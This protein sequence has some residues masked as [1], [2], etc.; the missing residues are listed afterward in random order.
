[1]L[2]YNLRFNV[3]KRLTLSYT[4]ERGE[5]NEGRNPSQI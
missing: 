1:M 4:H 5:H 2:E 3:Q